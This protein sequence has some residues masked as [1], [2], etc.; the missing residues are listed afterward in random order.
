LYARGFIVAMGRDFYDAVAG[1]PEVAV[2]HAEC[3]EM[4]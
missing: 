4:C 2:H 1:D 3:E